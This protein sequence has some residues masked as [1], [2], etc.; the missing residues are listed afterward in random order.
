[1]RQSIKFKS[2]VGVSLSAAMYGDT[3]DAVIRISVDVPD[4]ADS[5]DNYAPP[6]DLG[7][8]WFRYVYEFPMATG[9]FDIAIASTAD[10]AEKIVYL[11][12][13]QLVGIDEQV[14]CRIVLVDARNTLVQ[15][16]EL[17]LFVDGR[18]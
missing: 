9:A 3:R 4:P 13:E 5:L 15:T 10:S 14:H 8:L 16:G 2:E 11:L 18:G 1:M 12:L 17:D 7:Y 6:A